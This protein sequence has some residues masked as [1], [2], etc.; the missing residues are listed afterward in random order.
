MGPADYFCYTCELSVA[1]GG[2]THSARP[3]W[4]MCP[5]YVHRCLPCLHSQ[6]AGDTG[7]LRDVC[8]LLES[9]LCLRLCNRFFQNFQFCR[10]HLLLSPRPFPFPIECSSLLGT[11]QSLGLRMPCA[12]I[13]CCW[14]S[15]SAD[16]ICPICGGTA[17]QLRHEVLP[18]LEDSFIKICPSIFLQMHQP[19][20]SSSLLWS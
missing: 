9:R 3:S 13:C 1:Q 6:D 8:F 2:V 4:Y 10:I 18:S 12:G 5:T 17:V 20:A 15:P 11:R 7:C 14:W 16:S 19:L